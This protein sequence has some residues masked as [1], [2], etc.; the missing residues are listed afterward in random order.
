MHPFAQWIRGLPAK[1]VEGLAVD[2]TK[3]VLAVGTG[4]V[5]STASVASFAV[6]PEQWMLWAPFGAT[7]LLLLLFSLAAG[8]AGKCAAARDKPVLDVRITQIKHRDRQGNGV[9]MQDRVETEISCGPGA[10]LEMET[11]PDGS[12]RLWMAS[13]R[14]EPPAGRMPAIAWRPA[15]DGGRRRSTLSRR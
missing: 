14:N 9:A 3:V 7:G 6:S 15:T 1:L 5:A 13:S 11:R 4:S 2:A 12:F 10:G 8:I